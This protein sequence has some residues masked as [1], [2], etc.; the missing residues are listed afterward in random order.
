MCLYKS[1]TERLTEIKIPGTSIDPYLYK[2]NLQNKLILETQMSFLN[3]ISFVGR[4]INI[5]FLLIYSHIC[6]DA[7]Y[8]TYQNHLMFQLL[9]N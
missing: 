6:N 8:Y 9:K 1:S 3:V 7:I 5:F 2:V 4:E